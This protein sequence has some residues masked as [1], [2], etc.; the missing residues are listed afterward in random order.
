MTTAEAVI[1]GCP[2]A[3]MDPGLA[4][5]ERS[6]TPSDVC[7]VGNITVLSPH[8]TFLGLSEDCWM[9]VVVTS[10]MVTNCNTLF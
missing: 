9:E 8:E 7:V 6:K 1:E 4:P 3:S 5:S 2:V 10:F